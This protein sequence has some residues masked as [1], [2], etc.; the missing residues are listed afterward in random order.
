MGRHESALRRLFVPQELV[1]DSTS[2]VLR[3]N[4][5]VAGKNLDDTEDNATLLLEDMFPDVTQHFM[6][7]YERVYRLQATGR[8]DTERRSRIVASHRNRGGLS[9]AYFEA[10]G[11]KW[12]EGQY[13]VVLTEGSGIPGFIVHSTTPP[14]TILPGQVS[15]THNQSVY[16]ITVT[17]TGVSGPE[18]D[19]ENMFNRLKGAHTR[20]TYI[21]I[22]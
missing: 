12:G 7:D 20:F 13:T 1:G 4:F 5:Y 10:L 11:N 22:P 14:A 21:Y 17:V 9:K 15:T 2:D 19:L 18:E 6:G 16:L 3:Q 8:T